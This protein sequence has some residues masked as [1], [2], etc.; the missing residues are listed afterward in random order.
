[1]IQSFAKSNSHF[2]PTGNPFVYTGFEVIAHLA[3]LDNPNVISIMDVKRIFSDGKD[4]ARFNA[5]AKQYT[6]IFTTNG[7]LFQNSYKGKKEAIYI[8]MMQQLLDSWDFKEG[9]EICY[10]CGKP[11]YFNFE[12]AYSKALQLNGKTI[13]GRKSVGRDFMPLS[14]SLGQDASS[15]PSSS[16]SQSY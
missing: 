2:F 4:L 12:A 11:F 10:A 16:I 1:M 8:S 14:G 5:R 9:P 3:G 6:T 15:L 7:P 13:P